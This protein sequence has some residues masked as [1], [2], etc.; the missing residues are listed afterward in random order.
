MV[1]TLSLG[2]NGM[3]Q[4]RKSYE[5]NYKVGPVATEGKQFPVVTYDKAPQFSFLGESLHIPFGIPAGP[6]LNAEFVNAALKA[7]FCSPVYKTVRSMEWKCH[8]YPNILSIDAGKDSL[9]ASDDNRVVGKE[10]EVSDTLGSHL[11]ISNSFGVPSQP[12][13]VWSQDLLDISYS[14]GQLPMLS[15]Q[16]TRKQG[17]WDQMAGFVQ[18][19]AVVAKLAEA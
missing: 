13:E 6:L 1:T 4:A 5:E 12:V 19:T 16:G 18:D 8:P 11:S 7:G 2:I 17:D 14:K 9:F 3:Y 10:F 15:F